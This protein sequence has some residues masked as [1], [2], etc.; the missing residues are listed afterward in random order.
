MNRISLGL[1]A[2]ATAVALAGCVPSTYG[3]G[4]YGGYG[5]T[6]TNPYG[7]YG[8]TNPYYGGNS[9]YYGNNGGYYGNSGNG[10]SRPTIGNDGTFRCESNDQRTTRCL[11]DTR[12]GVTLVRQDSDAP[13]IQGR[14]W[15]TD[16]DGVWVTGG[17][18]ARFAIG[19]YGYGGTSNY[20]G[21]DAQTIRCESQDGRRDVCG[22]P[23]NASSVTISRQLSDTRCSQGYNWGW[24]G[25]TVWVD[26]GCRAE[27]TARY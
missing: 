23:F 21:R 14:T 4:N 9:G 3:Y 22:L 8:R 27:F 24:T 5:N 1:L 16:R 15:G 17:C 25:D 13:C 26:R 10:Y 2:A 20:Y 18:R 7:S 12:G 19:S 6:R 11:V